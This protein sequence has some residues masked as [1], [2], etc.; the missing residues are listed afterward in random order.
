MEHLV[1]T[2]VRHVRKTILVAY[3]RTCVT[4][5]LTNTVTWSTV[6]YKMQATH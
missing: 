5:L 6:V 1:S 2:V 4:V 3:A